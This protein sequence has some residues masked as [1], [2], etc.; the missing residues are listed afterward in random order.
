VQPA[1][2][3]LYDNVID[4]H[5]RTSNYTHERLLCACVSWSDL[6]HRQRATRNLSLVELGNL[7]TS[8][9]PGHLASDGGLPNKRTAVVADA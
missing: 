8:S 1:I 5:N 6:R 2:Q 4:I 9:D 7:H 3:A